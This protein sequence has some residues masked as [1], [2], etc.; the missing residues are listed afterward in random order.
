MDLLQDQELWSQLRQVMLSLKP[1]RA[2]LRTG[3][4]EFQF[5]GRSLE[6][7]EYREYRSGED[8][9]DMDWKVFARTDRYYLK[10]RD[11]HTPARVMLLLDDSP[12][13]R[14]KS[15]E[16]AISK[17]RESQLLIFA[18]GFIL[19]RQGDPFSLHSLSMNGPPGKARSSKSSLKNL[20]QV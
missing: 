16:A 19:H 18:L 14:M 7:A 8:L 13:M 12:S 3:I 15:D 9:R 11:S 4:H 17:L 1:V 6:F 5:R 10:Q 20:M 2:S